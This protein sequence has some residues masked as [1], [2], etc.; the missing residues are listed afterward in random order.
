MPN[1]AAQAAQGPYNNSV[2]AARRFFIEKM[3][4]DRA[5]EKSQSSV[6]RLPKGR[7]IAS[8]TTEER[9]PSKAQK[10]SRDEPKNEWWFQA[11]TFHPRTAICIV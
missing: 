3:R 4:A 8:F 2:L 6:T 10:K 5:Q 1:Q 11:A 9:D 7:R